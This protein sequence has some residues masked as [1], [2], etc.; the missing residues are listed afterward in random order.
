MSAKLY[1]IHALLLLRARG[2][3][4][5]RHRE[6]AKTHEALFEGL[7]IGGHPRG[8]RAGTGQ[9]RVLLL[10][11]LLGHELGNAG[12]AAHHL[13]LLRLRLGEILDAHDLRRRL[14][15][16]LHVRGQLEATL[17]HVEGV[18]AHDPDWPVGGRLGLFLLLLRGRGRLALALLPDETR[19]KRV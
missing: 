10:L 12:N 15:R 1:T 14:R 3:V 16:E 13:W 18:G 2:R 8:H 17:P 6:A 5:A 4:G 9:R 19:D 11:L 7:D